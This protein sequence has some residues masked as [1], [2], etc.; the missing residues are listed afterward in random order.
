MN[1]N[2]NKQQR[3]RVL[4]TGELGTVTDQV[5][6]KRGGKPMVYKQVRLDN[7]P[8]LD[9]WYWADELGGTRETCRITLS[10]GDGTELYLKVTHDYE[11][12]GSYTFY[13]SGKPQNLK[14][15]DL[16]GLPFLLTGA[17][18]KGLGIGEADIEMSVNGGPVTAGEK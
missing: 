8:H 2:N 13:A 10:G 7:H 18:L 5:L 1:K 16:R 12:Y 4:K 17:M 14:E 6:M 15:H 3:I 9:R 11:G